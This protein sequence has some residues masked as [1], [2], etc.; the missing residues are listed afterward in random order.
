MKNYKLALIP[1]FICLLYFAGVFLQGIYE[2]QLSTACYD[3]SIRISNSK[4]LWQKLTPAQ[5]I[6]LGQ[7]VCD[8]IVQDIG[9]QPII[10]AAHDFGGGSTNMDWNRASRTVRVNLNSYAISP[11][12]FIRSL[13][14]EILGHAVQDAL[15]AGEDIAVSAPPEIIE[16]W[17]ANKSA[18]IRP[19][20]PHDY[21]ISDYAARQRY[22]SYRGQSVEMHA[23]R[24]GADFRNQT[25]QIAARLPDDIEF[26]IFFTLA[27]LV[28]FGIIIK[29][30]F[31]DTPDLSFEECVSAIYD[32][33]IISEKL[34]KTLHK[35]LSDE[36]GMK[37][38]RVYISPDRK[39]R[40]SYERVVFNS[41]RINGPESAFAEVAGE[42]WRACSYE[43]GRRKSDGM[44]D[45]IKEILSRAEEVRFGRDGIPPPSADIEPT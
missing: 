17:R 33:E 39:K 16:Q 41:G 24:A 6:E 36:L 11:H 26:K 23:N 15:I 13:A 14:H 12:K 29:S 3:D 2:P 43:F 7:T 30:D 45:Y 25:R 44:A 31:E 38:L 42:T 37:P 34:L 32:N 4:G 9:L 18:Y 27:M 1:A 21:N 5:I 35:I 22:Q 10:I 19:P 40:T 20:L 28:I 8:R